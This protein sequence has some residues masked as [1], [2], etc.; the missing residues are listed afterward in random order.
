MAE[1]D[2]PNWVEHFLIIFSFNFSSIAISLVVEFLTQLGRVS[3]AALPRPE[4]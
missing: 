1:G 4:R 3:E 2:W